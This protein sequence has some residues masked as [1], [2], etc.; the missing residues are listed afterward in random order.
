M[1][2]T[3]LSV[4]RL[5]PCF[6]Y[7]LAAVLALS[8]GLLAHYPSSVLVWWLYMTVL[9]AMHVPVLLLLSVPGIGP[10]V[11]IVLL[12][13]LAFLGVH[14]AAWPEQYPRIRF[15]YAH[16]ALLATACGIIRAANIQAG[17][18]MLTLP[19]LLRGDWSLQLTTS[20]A[21]WVALFLLVSA[22]CLGS[23]MAIIR[24]IRFK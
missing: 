3:V 13:C 21:I 15:V 8:M 1:R 5:A 16:V 20:S 14:L 7:A 9:P 19:R 12:A 22:A 24:S 11:A 2:S 10:G 4:V 6:S 17:P 23:H 18:S